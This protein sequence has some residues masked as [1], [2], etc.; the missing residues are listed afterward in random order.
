MNTSP[1]QRQLA[2]FDVFIEAP[3]AAQLP[4]ELGDFQ[5][6]CISSRGTKLKGVELERCI[7]DVHW[8]CARYTFITPQDVNS[9]TSEKILKA[10][11]QIGQQ[12][13][14][15]SLIKLYVADGKP[16]YS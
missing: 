11:E 6:E 7:L 16:Q 15:S 5:L 9:K 8:L 1:Q 2:G 12:Y 4:K 13:N 3:F 10:V 14:W